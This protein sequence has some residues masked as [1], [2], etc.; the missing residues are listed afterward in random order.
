MVILWIGS[1]VDETRIILD[2]GNSNDPGSDY[3]N[4]NSIQVSF[5]L[6]LCVLGSICE[7]SNFMET[8]LIPTCSNATAINADFEGIAFHYTDLTCWNQ[9]ESNQKAVCH[10]K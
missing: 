4:A 9:F 1:T 6:A 2:D 8:L 7:N 10:A 5:I 3:I